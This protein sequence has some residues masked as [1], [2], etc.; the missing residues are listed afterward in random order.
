MTTFTNLS[1]MSCSSLFFLFHFFDVFLKMLVLCVRQTGREL[2]AVIDNFYQ[3]WAQKQIDLLPE[4][5]KTKEELI[6]YGQYQA[7]K[8]VW[9]KY[10]QKYDEILGETQAQNPLPEKN[11]RKRDDQNV[12]NGVH[13]KF[14]GSP[15]WKLLISCSR[16]FR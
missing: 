4:M 6:L 15:K 14:W 1:W 5:N 2:T 7:P 3:E 8:H 12:E 13:H 10:S 11:L 9:Q 16:F